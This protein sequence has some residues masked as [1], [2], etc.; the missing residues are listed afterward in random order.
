MKSVFDG[1]NLIFEA[2]EG[3]LKRC[4]LPNAEKRGE[5]GERFLQKPQPTLESQVTN[6]TDEIA[7]NNHDMDDGSRSGFIALEQGICAVEEIYS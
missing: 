4:S 2:R 7:Y 5:V 6:L 1:L 3:I